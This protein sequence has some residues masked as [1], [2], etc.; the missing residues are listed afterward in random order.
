MRECVGIRVSVCVPNPKMY[1]AAA[2]VARFR[3]RRVQ[4]TTLKELSAA[5]ASQSLL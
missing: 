1:C 4:L 3:Q 5:R 2:E